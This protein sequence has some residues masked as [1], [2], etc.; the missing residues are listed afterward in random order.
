[1][2]YRD[3]NLG[4]LIKLAPNDAA[5]RISQ[6]FAEFGKHDQ[7]TDGRAL[8]LVAARLDCSASSLKRHLRVLAELG[9][10]V[11]RVAKAKAEPTPKTP[12]KP[13]KKA[14]R[15]KRAA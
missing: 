3:S 1:M 2:A 15:K 6:A 9:I 8:D 10:E 13:V 5:A 4:L 14:G 7:E 12:K 11:R